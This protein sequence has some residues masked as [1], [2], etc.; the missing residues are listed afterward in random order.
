M[1]SVCTGRYEMP[2]VSDQEEVKDWEVRC[3]VIKDSDGLDGIMGQLTR[4]FGPDALKAAIV[5]DF[6]EELKKK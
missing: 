4:K 3:K 5:Q 2:E 6:V 1:I